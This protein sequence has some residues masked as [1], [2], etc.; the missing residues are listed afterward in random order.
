MCGG[1]RRSTAWWLGAPCAGVGLPALLNWLG[2]LER[3][4]SGWVNGA[5]PG[6]GR[7]VCEAQEEECHQR[8]TPSVAR[9]QA[10]GGHVTSQTT[11][12]GAIRAR[13]HHFTRATPTTCVAS[14]RVARGS[15]K[16][17]CA[18]NPDRRARTRLSRK[19]EGVTSVDARMGLHHPKQRKVPNKETDSQPRLQTTRFFYTGC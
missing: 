12:L 3:K 8:K 7:R 15:A 6:P 13:W 4:K 1:A 9:A 10:A 16:P 18:P 19:M 17:V 5:G 14:R 11:S 2:R